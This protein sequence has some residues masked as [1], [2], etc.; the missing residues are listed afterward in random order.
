MNDAIDVGDSHQ[1]QVSCGR[2]IVNKLKGTTSQFR[3]IR[4]GFIISLTQFDPHSITL[5]ARMIDDSEYL[6]IVHSGLL[7]LKN[8]NQ[9]IFCPPT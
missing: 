8:A 3:L 9:L 2:V 7:P 1:H 6:A 4:S 5:I